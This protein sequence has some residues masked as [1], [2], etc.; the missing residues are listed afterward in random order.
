M[1]IKVLIFAVLLSL[2]QSAWAQYIVNDILGNTT[3]NSILGS[4]VAQK[5]ELVKQVAELKKQLETIQTIQKILK[6][7]SAAQVRDLDTVFK[8]IPGGGGTGMA[9][10]FTN[11]GFL[12]VFMGMSANEFQQSV[13]DPAHFASS[14]MMSKALGVSGAQLEKMGAKGAEV[15]LGQSITRDSAS[16]KTPSL[17]TSVK[18]A[19][20]LACR[21]M[22]GMKADH[23][24]LNKL[25]ANVGDDG[26]VAKGASGKDLSS[27]LGVINNQASTTNNIALEQLRVQGNS[28]AATAASLQAQTHIM[29]EQQQRDKLNRLYGNN[30]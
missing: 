17:N 21:V 27:Q 9:G 30:K 5:A 6:D 10:L 26:K 8:N 12:D 7:P 3:L 24:R 14:N 25:S 28:N 23:E 15:S 1:K 20:L 2:A 18:I 19:D 4:N 11:A 16:G 13:T 29:T 22:E